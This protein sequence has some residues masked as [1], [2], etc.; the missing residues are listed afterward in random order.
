MSDLQQ[1]DGCGGEIHE[2]LQRD[3]QRHRHDRGHRVR[4]V[5]LC[6]RE[7]RLFLSLE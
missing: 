7:T 4:H 2:R 3:L 5:H 6:L 1:K